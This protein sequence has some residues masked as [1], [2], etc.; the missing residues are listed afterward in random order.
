MKT[1]RRFLAGLFVLLF[2][3]GAAAV[4]AHLLLP[5]GLPGL[6]GIKGAPELYTCPM[7]EDAE[8]RSDKPGKCPKCGMDLVPISE[9]KHKG[10]KPGGPADPGTSPAPASGPEHA[11]HAKMA[12]S[13]TPPAQEPKEQGKRLYYCPMHPTYTSDKPGECPICNMTLVAMEEDEG[14]EEHAGGQGV[15]G[16]ASINVPSRQRQL[17]G[18]TTGTVEKTH[19]KK[20]IR[21]VGRVVYDEKRLSAVT[22][23]FGVWVEELYV[24]AVGDHVKKGQPLFA[25]YS[26]DI[27]EAQQNY[28]VA[29][30]ASQ[31]LKANSSDGGASSTFEPSVRSARER[32]LLWDLTEDQVRDIEVKKKPQVRIAILSKVEGVVTERN[33]AQGDFVG[34]GMPIFRLADLSTVWIDAA[35][36]E[37]EVPLV[38]PGD[39]AKVTL[40]SFP[41]QT[42][43]YKVNF[44]YPY[45]DQETRSVRARLE[46]ENPEGK[47][48]PGMYAQATIEEDLGENLV[49]D[50]GAVFDTG[51]RQIVFVDLGEGRL[52]PREVKAG[53]R[54]DG[55][56]V[57]L[58]GLKEGEKVVTSGN[59][60]I[61]SE[62]RLKAARSEGGQVGG[63]QHGSMEGGKPG[64][65][66]GQMENMPMG[67]KGSGADK[68]EGGHQH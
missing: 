10:K 16:Y 68:P 19:V 17:I 47:L 23:K 51:K 38:K 58:E 5:G 54:A 67:D 33:A 7:V 63:H 2:L 3:V 26:P 36:Y 55:Q 24:K 56:V 41:G 49:V 20:P 13:P 34:A 22:L 42:F 30:E 8:V 45:M 1:P 37:Y 59:F 21:T 46:V 57:V 11:G 32:L 35:I 14:H 50:Q 61:D 27:L 60:L 64:G 9:T 40:P 44:V 25:I 15:E 66:S 62:S 12:G 43:E 53:S 65:A 52:E 39:M 48:K 28:L 18:V 29:L 6:L 4:G 31:A